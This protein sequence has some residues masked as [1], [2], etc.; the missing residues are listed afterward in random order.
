MDIVSWDMTGYDITNHRDKIVIASVENYR[1]HPQGIDFERI[2]SSYILGRNLPTFQ[3][4]I[5]LFQETYGLRF[6][7]KSAKVFERT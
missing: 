6:Q 4:H 5:H 3:V 1:H 2:Y 7:E